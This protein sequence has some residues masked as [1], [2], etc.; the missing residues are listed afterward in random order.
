MKFRILLLL[1]YGL[2]LAS[3][4]P[5][6]AEA[7]TQPSS[8]LG[9]GVGTYMSIL[10]V[11]EGCVA[12]YP[13]SVLAWEQAYTAIMRDRGSILNTMERVWT[14]TFGQVYPLPEMRA[15][16]TGAIWRAYQDR[17]NDRQLAWLCVAPEQFLSS[18]GKLLDPLA[19]QIQR[20]ERGGD[21]DRVAQDMR[22]TL[23]KMSEDEKKALR[24]NVRANLIASMSPGG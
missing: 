20:W 1:V 14:A 21:Y 17:L 6:A 5:V 24:A 8:V 10:A 16:V 15:E 9:A 12:I 4:R 11:R 3:V 18:F 2:F 22:R 7:E 13:Q 23:A 19:Y